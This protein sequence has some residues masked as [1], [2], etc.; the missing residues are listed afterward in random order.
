[1]RKKTAVL[2]IF[3]LLNSYINT[4]AKVLQEGGMGD[5]KYKNIEYSIA[6]SS[7][8]ERADKED[9]NQENS[10]YFIA[11]D[12]QAEGADRIDEK[13]NNDI[14]S[15]GEDTTYNVSFPANI[16]AYLDPGNLSGKGQI[17]SD[18]YIIENFGN[19]NLLIKIK[20]I[21]I[22][23]WSD[24]YIYEF[25]Q[26]AVTVQESRVKK[27]NVNMIWENE[28]E[29]RRKVLNIFDCELDEYVLFLRAAEYNKNGE[30]VKLNESSKGSFYFTG[31]L[32]AN[33]NL[34]WE[35]GEIT[36]SFDYEIVSGGIEDEYDE[37]SGNVTNIVEEKME[38][39]S[40]ETENM[41]HELEESQEKVDN[42][43]ETDNKKYDNN[44]YKET[45]NLEN[46]IEKESKG[47]MEQKK[48]EEE[49][50][51]GK[52]ED[53]AE[54]VEIEENQYDNNGFDIER[55]QK[56]DNMENEDDA[57]KTENFDNIES[58]KG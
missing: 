31:T 57:I 39:N 30:F 33:P 21:D 51:M 1:M 18:T 7:Q 16:H 22:N 29:N 56:G 37:F 44:S 13:N 36:V 25:S 38:K 4:F 26:E 35:D 41:I 40:E 52:T 55:E 10:E 20:N 9:S 48:S 8:I 43:V 27:L 2:L 5:S 42:E 23:Y 45:N 54:N 6:T 50:K 3:L 17:F 12:S 46:K 58:E 24:E 53:T 49:V 34:V 47:N 15:W 28:S 11:A 32:N 14:E 19:K